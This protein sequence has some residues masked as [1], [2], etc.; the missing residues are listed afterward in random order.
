MQKNKTPSYI[1]VGILT[2]LTTLAWIFFSVYRTLTTQPSPNIPAQVLASFSP[3][4]DIEKIGAIESRTFFA[5][6]EVPGFIT[7]TPSPSPSPE[8][9]PS[10]TPEESP[11]P[12]ETQEES[13]ESAD[14][15][16]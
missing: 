6:E 3:T 11:I 8:V 4:L 12:E 2:I 13:T 14:L 5:E 10:P 7:I 15:T 1:K 9:T 16:Q